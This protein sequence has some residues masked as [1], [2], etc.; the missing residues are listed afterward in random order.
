MIRCLHRPNPGAVDNCDPSV[1]ISLSENTLP[2]ACLHNFILERVWTATDDCGNSS[3]DTQLVH[4]V[5]TVAPVFVSVPSDTLLECDEMIPDGQVMVTDNCDPDP[6]VVLDEQT[7]PG[8]C[9]NEMTLLRTWTA[10]DDCGNSST[11]TQMISV[12]DTTAPVLTSLPQDTLVECDDPLPTDQPSAM[13]NCDLVLDL[14]FSEVRTD[15]SC[16]D[17]YVLTRTWTFT[18]DC[19]NASSH[20]Q[21]VFVVDTT[22]P[23]FSNIPPDVTLDCDGTPVDLIPDATDN[24]DTM[25][26]VTF[27]ENTTPD[28]LGN[29]TITRTWTATDNCGNTSQIT[30]Q[31][32]SPIPFPPS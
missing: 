23:V 25:V 3:R 9:A 13:D 19:G 7:T 21:L 10:T 29:A 2:G 18:D 8:A 17:K 11:A 28:C 32:P 30:Q 6:M 22:A 24:C 1:D 27:M 31:L 16:E 15:G 26:M 14:N 12:V 5:D 4:F 20:T